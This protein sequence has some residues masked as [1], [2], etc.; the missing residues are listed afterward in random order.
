MDALCNEVLF[1]VLC[2]QVV[3]V[4]VLQYVAIVEHRFIY[5]LLDGC[6]A[7]RNIE[8]PY[9]QPVRIPFRTRTVTAALGAPPHE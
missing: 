5:S 4:F 8:E 7:H 6:G 1:K 9:N 3:G 2:L